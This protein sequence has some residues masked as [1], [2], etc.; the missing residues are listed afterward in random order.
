MKK[1]YF[2][3]DAQVQQLQ[4]SLAHQRLAQS[5][6]S[7]DD[8]EYATRFNR[9]DGAINNL[10]FN[11][12]K[13]WKAVPRWLAP[14]VNQEATNTVSKEMT[15]VGRA[16][17]SR[18]IVD[19]IF[20]RYFHPALEP[21]LSSSLKV[22]ER[23]LRRFAPPTHTEEDKEAL[24]TKISNWRLAT[25][26]GLQDMLNT[27]EAAEYRSSLTNILVEMLTSDLMMNLKDPPPPGL[28]AGVVGIIEL[29]INIAANLPLESRD[30]FVDYVMP[31]TLVNEQ[32][33]KIES[34]LPPLTNPGESAEADRA[35]ITSGD[36]KDDDDAQAK[37]KG[38]MFGSLM[39]SGNKKPG[40][41]GMRSQGD[42]AEQKE[43][44]VRFAAFMSVEVKGKNML[45]KA[46]VYA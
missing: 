37:K 39:G 13:E 36:D 32:Y 15:A 22:I 2:D 5:R 45:V 29:A 26:D 42:G 17:I 12:R 31:G 19:E 14:Y 30:V 16:C 9:L 27:P 3:K 44:R 43:Q 18:W 8:N 41:A 33:M 20:D 1:Y 21:N 40:G 10:A 4:N 23:N 34:S 38:G 46:P 7:L 28:D 24:L 11:I 25:L 35:S 6:T